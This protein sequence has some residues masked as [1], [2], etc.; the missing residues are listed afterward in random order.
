MP[1][2]TV[3]PTP[4]AAALIRPAPWPLARH[5]LASGPE[6]LAVH[7]YGDAIILIRRHDVRAYAL[8]DGRLLG[9]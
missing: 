6:L 7:R 2:R 1:S 5:D 8:S 4:G 9:R 3:H